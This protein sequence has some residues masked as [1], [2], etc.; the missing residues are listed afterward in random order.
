MAPLAPMAS[1]ASMA[2]AR[3]TTNNWTIGL[4]VCIARWPTAARLQLIRCS[5]HLAFCVRSTFDRHKHHTIGECSMTDDDDDAVM[6]SP[7]RCDFL[8]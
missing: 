3:T 7:A 2:L 6:M 4:C 5:L 1:M 8:Y